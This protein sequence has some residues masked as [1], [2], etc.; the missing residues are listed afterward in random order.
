MTA[1]LFNTGSAAGCSSALPLGKRML[2]FISISSQNRKRRTWIKSFSMSGAMAFSTC[3]A[4]SFIA[5]PARSSRE[6]SGDELPLRGA[7][8][9]FNG[10]ATGFLTAFATLCERLSSRLSSISGLAGL[11]SWTGSRVLGLEWKAATR[12]SDNTRNLPSLIAE[13]E[14]ITTKKAK[15]SVMKSA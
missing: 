8:G 7:G 15:S 1:R 6:S 5:F 3:S 14:Y 4:I 13:M 10:S 9:I 11:P 12:A 2:V